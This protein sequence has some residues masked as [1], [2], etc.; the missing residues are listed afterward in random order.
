MRRNVVGAVI[1]T[2]LTLG[3]LGAAGYAVYQIGYQNGLA[4]TATEVVVRGG[5][6]WGGPHFFPPF[7]FFFGFLFLILLFGLISRMFF[8]GG[9]RRGWYGPGRWDD[10]TRSHMEQRLQT[11]HERAHET[12][13]SG[14]DRPDTT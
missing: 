1:G 8:W 10:D 13:R 7:G 3:V 12:D 2:I 6:H 14:G 4:E 9:G 5:P 11:W